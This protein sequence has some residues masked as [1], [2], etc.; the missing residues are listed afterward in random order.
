M[1][2]AVYV[3]ESGNSKINGSLKVDATYASVEGTCPKTCPFKGEGCYA[4]M[5]FV[6]ITTHRLDKEISGLTALDIAKAEAV[7]IDNAYAGKKVPCGRDLRLHVSGDARTIGSAKV[8]ASAIE[9][10]KNRGGGSVWTYTHAWKK[11][12]R[13]NWGN[14]IS[15]LASI[16]KAADADLA[17]QQGYAPALVVPNHLDNKAYKL[18]NSST[19]WVPCPAQTMDIGC[20][21][22]RLC[23]NGDGLL[24]RNTGITFA[25]HGP[26]QNMIKKKLPLMN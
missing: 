23:F 22:C 26:G 19:K 5:G 9:R 14:Q 11:V 17:R 2:G 20:T 1:N 18:P 15:V 21:D 13:S 16:E 3:S 8:I 12:P 7:A 10:W 6:A 25:A 4:Q 24:A